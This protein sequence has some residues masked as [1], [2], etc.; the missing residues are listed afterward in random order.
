MAGSDEYACPD[1]QEQGGGDGQ[2]QQ[3]VEHHCPRERYEKIIYEDIYFVVGKPSFLPRP[4][5]RIGHDIENAVDH[6][7]V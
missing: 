6:R 1:A 5:Q 2:A 3:A 7:L 4:H